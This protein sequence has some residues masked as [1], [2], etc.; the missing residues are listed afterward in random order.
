[1][2]F[3]DPETDEFQVERF[4]R[5]VDVIFMAQEILVSN[6]SYPTEEITAERARDAPA[7]PRLRQPGR[8]A[9]GARP[10]LRL[11][12]GPRLRGRD[13]GDHD[14]ARLPQVG[15]HGRPHRAVRRVRPQLRRH[16]ARDPQAPRRGRQHRLE[17]GAGRHARGRPAGVGRRAHAGRGPRLPQRPGRRDRA[18]G[19]DQLHDGLRHDRHR[20]RLLAGQVEAPGRRRRHHDRQPD[21]A[22]RAREARL[23]ARTRSTRSSPT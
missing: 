20:A 13:L 7:R 4:E 18:H 15:R 2:K 17:R 10:R 8:A 23:R 14:R 22:D 6:S 5:A 16:A 1:M 11:R 19:H 9:D 3:R 12:R 21:R